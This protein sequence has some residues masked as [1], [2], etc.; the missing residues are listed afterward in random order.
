MKRAERI[1]VLPLMAVLILGTASLF[2]QTGKSDIE[3][4]KKTAP[5]IYVDCGSCDID[6][7]KTEI[8]FVNYVR[9]RKEA[10]IHILVTTLRTG[11]GGRE[12][13]LS[14]LGQNE[15]AGIDDVQEYYSNKTDTDDEIRMGLVNALKMGLMTYVAKTPIS[16]R[17][18][19]DY[20]EPEKPKAAVDKWKSWVFSLSGHAYLNGEKSYKSHSLSGS[21]SASRVTPDIKIGLSL[22]SY[23]NKD[24]FTYEG[25][26]IRS[27][28]TTHEFE[29]LAVKSLSEHWSAGAFL[30]M[31]SSTYSNIRFGLTAAPAVEFNLFPYSQSTRR[32]LR[33][34]YKLAFMPIRYREETIYF[35]TRENLWNESLSVSLELSEKWGTI[36]TSLEGSHYFHDF[37]KNR[38][39]MFGIVSLQLYKGL[40]IFVLGSGSRL[41]GQLSLAK[42]GASLD[43]ILLRRRELATKYTYFFSVGFSYTF[44]SIFTNV[45]NPRFGSTGGGGMSVS[46][47][48]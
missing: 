3:A 7:I 19:I 34:L 26:S 42:G 40:S 37:S 23:H 18:S 27:T 32:Q 14:F 44:G 38:L 47:G 12:Y 6:Y 5:K 16:S 46:I 24:L 15:F 9:D 41:R 17:I 25:E 21:F 22:S 28:S 48:D 4:L 10:Q 35:K 11:G 39:S 31:N 45:V 33:F 30:S 29:G 43:E 1:L 20:S 36:S 8:T 2:A 13:T